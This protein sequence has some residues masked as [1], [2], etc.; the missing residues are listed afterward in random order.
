MC[1]AL[2]MHLTA[3]REF[4]GDAELGG[5]RRTISLLLCPEANVGDHVLVH[6]GYAIARIDRAE[7]EATLALLDATLGVDPDVVPEPAHG[8]QAR[9][10]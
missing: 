7:A 10:P 6:A 4:E 8:A 9:R 3:R 2:P 1:L 5:V